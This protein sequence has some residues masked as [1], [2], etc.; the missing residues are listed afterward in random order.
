M[1]NQFCSL[2]KY[3][4]ENIAV[5]VAGGGR[6]FDFC[7]VRRFRTYF[8]ALKRTDRSLMALPQ[9]GGAK[10]CRVSHRG[11]F[12]TIAE[13]LK[14]QNSIQNKII[15]PPTLRTTIFI[16]LHKAR[17]HKIHKKCNF[18]IVRSLPVITSQWGPV[19]CFI[20]S[21]APHSAQQSHTYALKF[22]K[23]ERGINLSPSRSLQCAEWTVGQRQIFF[24]CLFLSGMEQQ[25]CRFKKKATPTLSHHCKKRSILLPLFIFLVRETECRRM[26]FTGQGETKK[27]AAFKTEAISVK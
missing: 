27:K 26:W 3:S 10:K 13:C 21:R 1:P 24:S 2:Q 18:D 15:S 23:K 22:A 25:G 16:R 19:P 6:N 17:F 20:P 4:L 7:C 12:S 9:K 5:T 8:R 14:M 11:D